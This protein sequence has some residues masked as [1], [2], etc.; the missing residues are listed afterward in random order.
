MR[1]DLCRLPHTL[2]HTKFL[3]LYPQLV[4]T[5]LLGL[6]HRTI[7]AATVQY[8]NVHYNFVARPALFWC[9]VPRTVEGFNSKPAIRL[10]FQRD[11]FRDFAYLI[12]SETTVWTTRHVMTAY[13]VNLIVHT[14][15]A[16]TEADTPGT[17]AAT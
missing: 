16:D 7:N 9:D 14:A 5:T 11:P 12:V 13:A 2:A 17:P 6:V 8:L 4:Q 3:Q 1:C 10:L 15:D